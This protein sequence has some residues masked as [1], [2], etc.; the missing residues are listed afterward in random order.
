[1]KHFDLDEL[2]WLPARSTT[3]NNNQEMKS[4]ETGKNQ[5]NIIPSKNV[6]IM[7]EKKINNKEPDMRAIFASFY[8]DED[9]GNQTKKKK[10]NNKNKKMSGNNNNNNMKTT[11]V[12]GP[13]DVVDLVA[14]LL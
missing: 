9:S 4:M 1:M 7:P 14:D 12:Q 6:T 13:S 5:S 2:L 10:S 3:T 8:G 11:S